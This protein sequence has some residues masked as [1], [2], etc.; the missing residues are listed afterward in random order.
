MCYGQKRTRQGHY[1]RK[2]E[3]DHIPQPQGGQDNKAPDSQGTMGH[4]DQGQ[5][6]VLTG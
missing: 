5:R 1:N 2:G 4:G 3:A 6:G